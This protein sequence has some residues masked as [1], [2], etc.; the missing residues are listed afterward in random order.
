[1]TI[2]PVL[3]ADA[4]TYQLKV[5]NPV[6]TDVASR[7]A[8]L[9]VIS[10]PVTITDAS[11]PADQLVSE[12]GSV[13][14]TVSAAGSAPLTYQWFKGTDPIPGA[15]ESSYSISSVRVS[16]AGDYRVT[17]SNPLPSS[18][19]SRTARLS[20]TADRLPPAVVNVVGSVNQIIVTFSEP[21]D[22]T[23]ASVPGNFTVSGGV[24]VVAATRSSE[25]PAEVTL[26][27]SAQAFGTLHCVAVSN[28]RDLFNNTVLPDTSAPFVST[29]L[30][31]GSFDDWT[32]V[33]L[34]HADGVDL[35]TASDYQNVFIT[36]D[37]SH[38]FIRVS[39]HA[40][41]DLAIFYNNIFVDGDNASTGYSFRLGS[42]M[43]IQGGAGYQQKNG[44]FNEG[45]INGLD[46]AIQPTG[47]GTDFEFRIS[48]GAT[49]ANDGLPV[50][51]SSTIALV[52]DAESTSF[53]TVDTAPDSGALLYTLFDAPSATLG[54]LSFEADPFGQLS[55]TWSGPGVL[56]SRSSLTSGQWETIWDLAPPF[57]IGEPNGQQFYRLFVPCE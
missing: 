42:E 54:R 9:N 37:A 8:V 16:D 19:T 23:S 4:G 15:T 53:Q 47:V 49:F 34:A 20:V 25:N 6:S 52:F 38:I 2:S 5:S 31:D 10:T 50:F 28:V 45:G 30:I 44:G 29:I 1:L 46:W 32:E 27:T 36:N 41:S 35:P 33:P 21:V 13:T 39:L 22:E 11:Q 51:T 26:T 24:N 57:V 17:V 18:A 7:A 3:A 55:V 43:L 56:Q 48:R 12:G 40:A 14:F